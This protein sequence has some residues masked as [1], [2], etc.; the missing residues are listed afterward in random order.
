MTAVKSIDIPTIQQWQ[1][2]GEA[3]REPSEHAESSI[4]GAILL[5]QAQVTKA[6]LMAL[7]GKKWVLHCRSGGRSNRVCS[8]LLSED[9]SF[10]V[11]NLEG[12]IRAWQDLLDK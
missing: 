6:A 3:V 8:Q 1:K 9:A 2:S 11:Y 12:G 4:P 7:G 5:P 10:E